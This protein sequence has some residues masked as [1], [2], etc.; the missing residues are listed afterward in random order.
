[1]ANFCNNNKKKST[2]FHIVIVYIG[3]I[4]LWWLCYADVA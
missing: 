2:K 4:T 3:V 1:M